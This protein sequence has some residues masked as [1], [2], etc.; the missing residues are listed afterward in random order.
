MRRERL[1]VI[2]ITPP[3]KVHTAPATHCRGLYLQV[4]GSGR[5]RHARKFSG[6]MPPPNMCYGRPE[7]GFTNHWIAVHHPERRVVGQSGPTRVDRRSVAVEMPTPG[8]SASG[9]LPLVC[10]PRAFAHLEPVQGTDMELA[11]R[12]GGSWLFQAWLW[13]RWSRWVTQP[14]GTST[15]NANCTKRPTAALGARSG[16]H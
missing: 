3:K 1:G 4:F 12:D 15:V 10:S 7:T 11:I 9:L 6:S 5:T 8:R 16:F 14:G 13:C 2:R